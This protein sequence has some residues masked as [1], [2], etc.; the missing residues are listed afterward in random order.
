MMSMT[1]TPTYYVF[2]NSLMTLLKRETAHYR[3]E[4]QL[5]MVRRNEWRRKQTQLW[6]R[7]T[8]KAFR[9]WMPRPLPD[10]RISRLIICVRPRQCSG[11]TGTS[12]LGHV[13]ER[14]ISITYQYSVSFSLCNLSPARERTTYIRHNDT[15]FLMD[16]Y[17]KQRTYNSEG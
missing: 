3:R 8:S 17:S 13:E 14:S 4:L 16:T 9:S 15:S 1:E 11:M 6:K 7:F 10:I 5:P 2:V 12:G